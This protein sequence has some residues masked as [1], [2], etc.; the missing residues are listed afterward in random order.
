MSKVEKPCIFDGS[1]ECQPRK[2]TLLV[3][4]K[5]WD[6]SDLAGKACPICPIRERMMIEARK[7]T[8]KTKIGNQLAKI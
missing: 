3:G 5:D 8:K 4:L 7:T 1:V 2:T 6:L